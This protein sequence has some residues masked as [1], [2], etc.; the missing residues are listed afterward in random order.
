[1]EK[2]VASMAEWTGKVPDSK[3][4]ISLLNYAV[5]KKWRVHD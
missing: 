4:S 3:F 5:G 1:M 2:M